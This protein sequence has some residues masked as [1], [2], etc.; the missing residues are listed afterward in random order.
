[1]LQCS[2]HIYICIEMTKL[3]TYGSAHTQSS[4][5][6]VRSCLISFRH[7][8]CTFW[9][10]YVEDI[11]VWNDDNDW[12]YI[13]IRLERIYIYIYNIRGAQRTERQKVVHT[14]KVYIDVF[15]SW[16]YTRHRYIYIYNVG[17]PIGWRCANDIWL[18]LFFYA[19]QNTY[20]YIQTKYTR[21]T[22][23]IHTTMTRH[24]R[25]GDK[26]ILCRK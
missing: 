21:N 9:V 15:F 23:K 16:L 5:L 2:Q 22:Y 12:V 26:N 3:C 4:V 20:I 11:L 24:R 10:F 18:R 14:L 7:D 19:F 25:R 13:Y 8:L 1:M 17:Q 6:C